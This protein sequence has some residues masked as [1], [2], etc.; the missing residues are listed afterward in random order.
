MKRRTLLKLSL[1][2]L[3][4]ALA[5][6]ALAD[7][8]T[9]R[10]ARRQQPSA[11][12]VNESTLLAFDSQGEPA[13]P[14][15]LKRTEVRA[16]VSGFI[17]RVTVTQDF[18]NPF[19]EKIEA[20]YTF[21]LPASAAVD[22]MT[23]RVGDR[24]IKGRIMRRGEARATYEAARAKG[25]LASLLNQQRPNVFTQSVA[26]IQPGQQVRVTLSYVEVLKYE[27]GSYEWSFPTVVG[28][29]YAP[30]PARDANAGETKEGGTEQSETADA[31]ETA[32]QDATDDAAAQ[33]PGAS[34]P[35]F[36]VPVV[37]EGMRAG[38]D[39]TIEVALDA[40]VPLDGLKSDTHEIEVERP[41]ERRA[42]V[43]LKNRAA[44]PNRDF[45]MKYDVAGRKIED[46]VLAHRS[47]RGGFF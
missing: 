23:M 16:E 15:P 7:F 34:E 3:V 47:S 39:I 30:Q 2:S 31:S 18:H 17:S 44:I 33:S 25:Q 1:A 26:N 19:G 4:F 32:T 35:G 42:V 11:E 24:T 13:G 21:P 20:V 14:C 10:A 6:F 38:H 8:G 36:D 28:Q 41:D 12:P 9:A 37:P 22:D 40:G 5:T 45:V 27:G 43:R 29:R 46:A